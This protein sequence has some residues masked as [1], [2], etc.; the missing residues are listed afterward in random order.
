VARFF[1]DENLPR[2]LAPALRAAGFA[3]EDVRD[4]GRRGRAD[5][6]IIGYARTAGF[7]LLTSD[8]GFGSVV[9]FPLGGHPGIIVVRFPNEVSVSRLN[10]A[11]LEAL[12]SLSD[13]DIAGNLV[14]IE[15]GRLRLRRRP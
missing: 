15:P 4:S 3:P 10:R 9:R 7:V 14:V 5:D 13:D 1:I 11:V 6:E 8:V 12:R 2:S